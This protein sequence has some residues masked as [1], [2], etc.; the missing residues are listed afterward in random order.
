MHIRSQDEPR[1][2]ENF[3]Y[4][5]L[6]HKKTVYISLGTNAGVQKKMYD[7]FVD[8]FDHP[9]FKDWNVVL[10]CCDKSFLKRIPSNFIIEKFAP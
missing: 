3:P 4:H 1:F 8:T 6:V 9:L 2:K 5:K 10:M 7:L